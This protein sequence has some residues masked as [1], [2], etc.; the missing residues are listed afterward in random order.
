MY[1]KIRITVISLVTMAICV[2]SSTATLS[3]FTDTDAK[4][5]D[6]TVG[7]ASTSLAIYDELTN[8]RRVFDAG[9]YMLTDNLDIP[10]YP[11]ATNDG[12]IP[13][14]QRFRVVI[15]ID[16]AQVVTLNLPA[17]DEGCVIS[18]ASENT[19]SNSDYTIV[20]KPSVNVENTSTYAE[21]YITSNNVLGVDS[22]TSE[23]PITGI[24]ISGI[25]GVDNSLFV[26]ANNNNNSCVLGVNVYSDAIQT[27]GF[28]SAVDAFEDF[29]ETF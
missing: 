27:T 9:R 7:N 13:V 16:L 1:R 28:S 11:Q 15:P 21:Y 25:S 14:Y 17:M 4:T 6:F 22:T 12:N 29:A 23:W 5:N 24:H 18:T 2:L 10:F 3:Y 20:Y 26:C 19:C 8:S